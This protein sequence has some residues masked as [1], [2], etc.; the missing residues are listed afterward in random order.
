MVE[1]QEISRKHRWKVQSR[2]TV[3]EYA[4]A[5]GIRPTAER[6]GLDRKTVREKL[7]FRQAA[8]LDPRSPWTRDDVQEAC[9]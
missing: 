8:V 4:A 9:V 3:L 1:S 2:V 6:F 7:R 5:H